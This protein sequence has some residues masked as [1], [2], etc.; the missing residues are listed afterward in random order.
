MKR[1]SLLMFLF[2]F[3]QL[4][5]GQ[6]QISKLVTIGYNG[7]DRRVVYETSVHMEAPNWTPD[8]K[9]LIFNAE[10]R[11]YKIPANGAHSPESISTGN[12]EN[13]NNDHGITPDGK[14]IIFSAGFI[15]KI[16]IEGG[17]PIQVTAKKPSYWHGISPNG[18][19]LV[20]CAKRN[21]NFDIYAI[22]INGGKEIR[23]TSS[24]AYDDGP[25][26]SPDGQWIYFNSNRSGKWEIWKI[27]ASGGKAIQI[28]N[29][30]YENWFPHPS[31]DGKKLLFLSFPPGTKGH[32][33]NKHVKIRLIMLD[34]K[35]V[36]REIVSLFGGQGTIN[37]PSWS[38]DSKRFAY[39]EYVQSKL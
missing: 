29:D 35:T 32:P 23:L 12:I 9:F 13:A 25:E 11:L 37:V 39:V 36:I 21:D 20:Y 16:P 33:R 26:Y 6:N 10:G 22:S 34:K 3:F 19:T 24:P 2:G 38:P 28:T 27:P 8:G 17:I 1:R 5:Y 4:T 31:P 18:Q 15:Y 14:T 7:T 30:K